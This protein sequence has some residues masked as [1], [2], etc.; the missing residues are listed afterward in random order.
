MMMMMMMILVLEM[1]KMIM[2]SMEWN[3]ILRWSLSCANYLIP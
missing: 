1:M 3:N 2:I